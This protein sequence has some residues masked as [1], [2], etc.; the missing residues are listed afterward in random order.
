MFLFCLKYKNC[1]VHH[2]F[3]IYLLTVNLCF[4]CLE[5]LSTDVTSGLLQ[6]LLKC[7]A[8]VSKKR[9][10]N[11][12]NKIM[13]ECFPENDDNS[14]EHFSQILENGSFSRY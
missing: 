13:E 1:S 2:C 8:F 4:N 10:K 12:V 14:F 6:V 7:I 3:I 9:F 11:L 5:M